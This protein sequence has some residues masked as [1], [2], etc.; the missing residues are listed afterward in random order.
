MLLGD[1]ATMAIRAFSRRRRCRA[2]RRRPGSRVRVGDAALRARVRRDGSHSGRA[3]VWAGFRVFPLARST[4]ARVHRSNMARARARAHAEGSVSCQFRPIGR[5]PRAHDRG[6]RGRCRARRA[7]A[8]KKARSACA[9][10]E[11]A[12]RAHEAARQLLGGLARRPRACGS[13]ASTP[14]TY[15]P[16]DG[17]VKISDADRTRDGGTSTSASPRRR[18][19]PRAELRLLVG[20]GQGA[21]IRCTSTARR[22]RRPIT[23]ARAPKGNCSNLI[24]NITGPAIVTAPTG[25]VWSSSS[26]PFS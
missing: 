16:S 8:L 1:A 15:V 20:A 22:A 25:G 17:A 10:P 6:R 3:W 4:A 13:G 2:R 21:V 23:R 14:L 11:A 9:V 24:G 7:A 19:S 5:Q 26:G 12:R 18:W